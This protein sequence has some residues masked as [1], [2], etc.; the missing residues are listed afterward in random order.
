MRK[1][2]SYLSLIWVVFLVSCE[3]ETLEPRTNPRFSVTIIQEIST[4]GVQL[5]ADIYDYGDE[6]IL[7]YGFVYTQSTGAPNL[8]QDD[9]VSGQG[10]PDEH[11]ELI[12]NHS[13]TIGKKYFVSAFLRTT[14]SLVF[15]KSMEFVSQGSAGF[16][17]NSIEWPDVIYKDQKLVVKGQ[18]FS[19]Q[20]SNY[21]IK[22][23]QFDVY[24]DLVDSNTFFIN[25]PMGLLTQTTGQDIETELRIEI[26][27]KIYTEKRVLKFQEPVFESQT[28]Q[29]IDFDEEVIIKGDFLDL[30][31]IKIKIGNQEIHGLTANKNE[32]RFFPFNGTGL[33]PSAT[34]PEITFIV[35]GKSYPLGKIFRIDGPKISEEK[36]FLSRQSQ[37]IPAVN[38]NLGQL[39]DI[40]FYDENGE[41]INLEVIE[42][43]T[44]GITVNSQHGIYPGRNFKM[45]LKSFGLL[46]NFAEFEIANPVVVTKAKDHPYKY[47]N[48]DLA[49]VSNGN[50]YILTAQG[51][52]E[53][54]LDGQFEQRKI[55][56]LPANFSQRFQYIRQVVEG[57][58]VLGGGGNSN[59]QAFFDLYYFSLEKLQ[60]EKLPDLPA[61]YSSFKLVTSKNG[62]LVFE[63]A[64][65]L[66]DDVIGEKWTLNLQTKIWERLPT[67]G[68]RYFVTQ[69]FHHNSETYLYGLNYTDERRSIYR[70]REDFSWELYIDLPN[71]NNSV[72]AN[73]IAVNGKYYIISNGPYYITEI[74]LNTKSF[75]GFSYPLSFYYGK[76]PVVYSQGIYL[77]SSENIQEDIRLDLF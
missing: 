45:Q 42:A 54:T 52:I 55:T 13:L 16:I 46:S 1:I 58:F 41:E 37:L 40:K 18:R 14:T 9:F 3:K 43:N 4:S 12:A 21:K 75:G 65:E 15:S 26:N 30:G 77:L 61:P 29:T 36:I 22:L 32:F 64:K 57:G 74:D 71:S 5:G 51:I 62:F 70:M 8:N 76:V 44:S 35:R 69:T 34:E 49:L 66:F 17:I 20:I 11:F 6:E 19:K 31:Q 7:E 48:E 68:N 73:P 60:W 2:A 59:Y 72:F 50:A 47:S 27:E 33:I 38:F 10:R 67:N 56:D 39:S 25:L 28:I 63:E 24:P 53:E 23:G